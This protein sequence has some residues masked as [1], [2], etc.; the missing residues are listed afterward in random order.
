M[1]RIYTL[2]FTDQDAC[3][4]IQTGGKGANLATLTQA[5]FR[6]PT[7]FCVTT[8]AYQDHIAQD[9]ALEDLLYQLDALAPDHRSSHLQDIR[10]R[11]AA[12][13]L[14]VSLQTEIR[15]HLAVLDPRGQQG[16]AVRSSGTQEDQQDAAFA[17][18]HDT[19]L[20]CRGPERVLEKIRE[21]FVSLWSDRAV[22]YR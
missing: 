22:A 10:H 4:K 3:D 5:G 21:G 16:W 2:L 20:N 9:P 8:A 7:G 19:F 15:D 11:I 14:P 17:G 13:P 1:S 18:Q 6:V 12:L